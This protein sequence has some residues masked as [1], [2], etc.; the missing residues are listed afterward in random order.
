MLAK[1]RGVT[2]IA[3]MTLALGI[4]ANTALFSVINAVL[5]RTLPYQDADRLVIVWE[6]SRHNAQNTINLGNFSDWQAQNSVFADMAAFVDFRIN[7]TS[8]GEPEEIAMQR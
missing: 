3:V 5:L 8:D 6:K 1:Q 4:G 7:L 2:V